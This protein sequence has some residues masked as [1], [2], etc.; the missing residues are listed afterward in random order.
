MPSYPEGPLA[1]GA[2]N[3]AIRRGDD[4]LRPKVGPAHSRRGV[5]SLEGVGLSSGPGGSARL[6]D[7]GPGRNTEL[8][9]RFEIIVARGCRMIGERLV[10]E[11]AERRRVDE[12]GDVLA[13]EPEQRTDRRHD[14]RRQP[15][16]EPAGD[17]AP[18]WTREDRGGPCDEQAGRRQACNGPEESGSCPGSSS[19]R[20]NDASQPVTMAMSFARFAAAR[21]RNADASNS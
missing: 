3:G 6:L 19:R 20:P 11:A 17:G 12:D 7:D 13:P 5:Q 21:T 18:A 9:Q 16:H 10:G 8:E 4:T 15:E 14:D 2:T 1:A